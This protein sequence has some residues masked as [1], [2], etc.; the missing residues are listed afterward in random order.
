[1]INRKIILFVLGIIT[2]SLSEAQTTSIDSI[3]YEGLWRNYRL[4]LPT[5]FNSS[6]QHPL[7]FNFHGYGSNAYE[8]E[9]Y[10][11]FDGI[12]DTANVVVCY[13]N[14]INNSW[15][16]INRSPDDVRLIDTLI[17]VIHYSY[18]I[19]LNRVYAT[20]MSNGGFMC[21]YLACELSQ[22][23]AAIAPV[24]GTNSISVQSNCVPSRHVPVLY[25]HGT[26]DATVNYLGTPLFVSAAELMELWSNSNRCSTETDTSTLADIS[27][28]DQCTAEK[29]PGMTATA[30]NRLC[31]TEL[32]ME[33]THGQDH[34]S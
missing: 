24:A 34:Q 22:R 26:A 13:P 1:M 19:N 15:N 33:D 18:N 12:A 7:V 32:S 14:G 6:I 5:G 27:S 20:G 10:S 16:A 25:I 30:I 23:L 4:F 9:I 28:S 3:F 2:F 11:G 29:F 8:Q 31:I 17:T 21:N